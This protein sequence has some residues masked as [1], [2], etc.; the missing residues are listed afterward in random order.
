MKNYSTDQ[1]WLQ[2][3]QYAI[4]II[5]CTSGF[6][7]YIFQPHPTKKKNPKQQATKS[8]ENKFHPILFGNYK[9]YIEDSSFF[10][11][12]TNHMMLN[13][14][15]LFTFYLYDTLV[16]ASSKSDFCKVVLLCFQMEKL[17]FVRLQRYM[18]PLPHFLVSG[19]VENVIFFFCR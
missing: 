14:L 4:I 11:S 18:S 13:K 2:K 9:V 19:K 5:S 1:C 8:N 7:L 15:F 6:F 12:K 16:L 3:V 10:L 17:L